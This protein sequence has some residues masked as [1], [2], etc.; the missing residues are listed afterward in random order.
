[1]MK[2]LKSII[3]IHRFY[4]KFKLKKKDKNYETKLNE[5]QSAKKIKDTIN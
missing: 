4:T 5:I 3:I 2:K 1:M